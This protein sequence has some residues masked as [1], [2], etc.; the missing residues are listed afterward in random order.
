M[1]ERNKLILWAG[2]MI[3]ITLGVFFGALEL[4]PATNSIAIAAAIAFAVITFAFIAFAAVISGDAGA[5]AV[6]GEAVVT[7]VANTA[8]VAVFAAAGGAV[9]ASNTAFAVV[10]GGAV[11]ATAAFAGVDISKEIK[12]SKK[13]AVS[14]LTVEGIIIFGAMIIR[15]MLI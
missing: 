4:L 5:G 15:I 2:I 12:I 14:I 8:A 1:T 10:V 11:V 6:G 9:V 3:V 13:Q 7:A